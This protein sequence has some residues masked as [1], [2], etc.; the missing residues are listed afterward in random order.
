MRYR[1]DN[2]ER[3]RRLH[4]DT[5]LPRAEESLNLTLA[6]YRAGRA[7]L[8]DLIDGEQLLL[9]LRLALSRSLRDEHMAQAELRE[10]LGGDLE[11]AD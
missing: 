3:A 5:L 4:E 1:A 8:V 6:D 7:S 10:L 2:A 11:C 9:D